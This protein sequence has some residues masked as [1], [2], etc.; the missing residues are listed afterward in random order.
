MKVGGNVIIGAVMLAIFAGMLAMAAQYPLESR[1][2][3][4]LVG[5]F[6]AALCVIQLWQAV[7][8]D[9]REVLTGGEEAAPALLRREMLFLGWFAGFIAGIVA[10][11]FLIAGPA[12]VFA[13]LAINQRENITRAAALAVGCLAVLYLVFEVLLELTLFRGLAAPLLFG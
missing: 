6:G 10:L 12:L 7:A 5:L 8:A 2:M 1:F 9:R 11:G 3:P 13:F 4:S